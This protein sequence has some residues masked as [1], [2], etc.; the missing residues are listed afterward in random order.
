MN[1]FRKYQNSLL[2]LKFS[3]IVDQ[4]LR[5]LPTS[6]ASSYMHTCARTS[7]K[8]AADGEVGRNWIYKDNMRVWRIT[9]H[10][11]LCNHLHPSCVTRVL[12]IAYVWDNI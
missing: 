10:P 12:W 6:T 3:L 8:E 9:Q 7:R 11:E 2:G 4:N 1:E 5:P